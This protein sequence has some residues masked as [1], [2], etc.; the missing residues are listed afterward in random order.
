VEFVEVQERYYR[1]LNMRRTGQR[2]LISLI[3]KMWEIAWSLWDHRNKVQE[4]VREAKL[5]ESLKSQTRAIFERG[6]DGLH[7][8]SRRLFTHKTMEE[9]LQQKTVHLQAWVLRVEAAQSRAG[10]FPELIA[11]QLA[12]RAATQQRQARRR[13][14]ADR[15]YARR[16]TRY[17]SLPVIRPS[18]LFPSPS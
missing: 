11:A 14:N 4:R 10:S 5:R 15:A 3:K 17:P 7:F 13:A 8:A 9:R 18:S 2:W 16:R 1:F 12:A 6:S